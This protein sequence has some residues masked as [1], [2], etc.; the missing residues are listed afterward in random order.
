MKFKSKINSIYTMAEEVAYV[1]YTARAAAHMDKLI[2]FAL[3]AALYL[4]MML[5]I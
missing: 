5:A 1:T 2:L 4:A 3:D